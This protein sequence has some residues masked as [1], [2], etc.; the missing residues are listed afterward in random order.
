MFLFIGKT[1]FIYAA[2]NG[3][4]DIVEFLVN[5]GA[6]VNV[7]GGNGKFLILYFIV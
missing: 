1:P 4:L 6:D 7:K 5:N 2:D 3:Y